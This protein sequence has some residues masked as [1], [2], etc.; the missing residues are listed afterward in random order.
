MRGA[1]NTWI[2]A[3]TEVVSIIDFDQVVQDPVNPLAMLP[4]Y[5]SGDHLHPGDEGYVAM[6][7]AVAQDLMQ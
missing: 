4:A 1:V 2:R 6:A 5:D 3:N 7:A